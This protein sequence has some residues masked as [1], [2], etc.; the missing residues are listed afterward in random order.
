MN[1]RTR[2]QIILRALPLLA[3]LFAMADASA[4]PVRYDPGFFGQ[5]TVNHGVATHGPDAGY[6]AWAFWHTGD[7]QE[8]PGGHDWQYPSAPGLDSQHWY[9]HFQHDSGNHFH[10]GFP[11][12]LSWLDEHRYGQVPPFGYGHCPTPSLIPLPATL[13]LLLSGLAGMIGLARPGRAPTQGLSSP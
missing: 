5:S 8:S 3:M 1:T 11:P 10:A 4:S 7:D 6:G 9:D 12:G 13:V 2:A